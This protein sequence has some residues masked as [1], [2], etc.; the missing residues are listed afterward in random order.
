MIPRY[1]VARRLRWRVVSVAHVGPAQFAA[2]DERQYPRRVI[3]A[4]WTSLRFG[5]FIGVLGL[6]PAERLLM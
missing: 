5:L 2:R 1:D 6:S 4:F 3:G